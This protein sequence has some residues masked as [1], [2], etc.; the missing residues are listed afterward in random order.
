[1]KGLVVIPAYN[2]QD[3]IDKILMRM[4]EI[5]MDSIVIDD[6]STDRTKEIAEKY[7][8]V[9]SHDHN[10]GKGEALKSGFNF[11]LE[12]K[13]YDFLVVIDADFQ[14]NPSEI[15]RMIKSLEW[16]DYV[17]G[18][19]DWNEVP[20]RHRLGNW[21]WV[22]TFRFLYGTNLDDICCG[23]I[24]MR[25][26]VVETLKISGGYVIDSY[27]L[28]QTVK[29]GFSIGNCSVSVRYNH[30]RSFLSGVRM[31]AGILIFMIKEAIK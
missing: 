2:E 17:V 20:F 6:G 11:F 25:R 8:T 19:R 3:H 16:F 1:M 29:K 28:I 26:K 21:V 13:E 5:G 7:T 12:N 18:M 22:K 14:Y 27:M 23:F 10:K 31:V 30:K 24:A 15:P 4:K 9:I